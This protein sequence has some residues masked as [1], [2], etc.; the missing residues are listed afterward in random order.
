MAQRAASRSGVQH[1]GGQ[2][3]AAVS[4][5]KQQL[6]LLPP[7]P[8]QVRSST[9]TKKLKQTQLYQ[10]AKEIQRQADYIMQKIKP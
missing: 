10:T 7:S 1:R 6:M 3:G 2:N 4:L 8:L 9:C 5:L